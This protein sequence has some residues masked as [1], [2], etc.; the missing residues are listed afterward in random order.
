MH[1]DIFQR[2]EKTNITSGPCHYSPVVSGMSE[3]N[4]VLYK[5]EALIADVKVEV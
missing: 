4:Q 3:A 5:Q 2:D 1:S